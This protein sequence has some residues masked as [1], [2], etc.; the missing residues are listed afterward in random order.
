MV[1]IAF[2][3]F[4]SIFLLDVPFPSIVIAAALVGRVGSCLWPISFSIGGGPSGN[5]EGY[6]PPSST[7]RRR[8][9]IRASRMTGSHDWL[10]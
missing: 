3:A 8:R 4:A 1:A 5:T 10:A 9:P 7:T 2:A 6:G